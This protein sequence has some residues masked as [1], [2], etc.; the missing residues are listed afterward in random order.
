M[1]RL[2]EKRVQIITQFL[3]DEVITWILRIKLIFLINSLSCLIQRWIISMDKLSLV[4]VT[5]AKGKLQS[6]STFAKAPLRTVLFKCFL[7]PFWYCATYR[8]CGYDF[9]IM[10]YKISA[11]TATKSIISF[12][13]MTIIRT[14]DYCEMVEALVPFK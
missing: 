12:L 10:K 3:K 1:M 8:V 5:S 9:R 14:D 13:I 11:C 4:V 2:K 6:K 7:I